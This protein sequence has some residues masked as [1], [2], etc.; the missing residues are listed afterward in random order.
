MCQSLD[1]PWFRQLGSRVLL[2]TL[3]PDWIQEITLETLM[4][5]ERER[6]RVSVPGLMDQ[7]TME[8]GLMALDTVKEYSNR[9]KAQSMMVSLRMTSDMDQAIS[10]TSVETKSLE[11]G[12]KIDLMVQES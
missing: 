6:V 5:K 3:S 4:N 10:P 12:T 1:I 7:P 8:S 9:E 2:L 11:P